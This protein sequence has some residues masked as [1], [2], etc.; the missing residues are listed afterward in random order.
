[1]STNIEPADADEPLARDIMTSPAIT[2][3]AGLP[4]K[5]LVALFRDR[6]IGGAPVVDDDGRL[7]GIVTEG[8]LMAMDADIALPHYF[9]IFDSIIYL[10]SEKKF[11]ERVEKAAA[12]SVEQLMTDGDKV[13]T[14]TP[15]DPA[16]KA[17]T[18]MSKH[19]FDRVPV[20]DDEGKVVGIVTRHDIMKILGL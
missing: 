20:V 14:V 7:I 19:R 15:D 10:E 11:R 16:R 4:V 17:A 3:K 8:D 18:L 1:M 12:A 9:E 6:R 2:V 5:D 13:K